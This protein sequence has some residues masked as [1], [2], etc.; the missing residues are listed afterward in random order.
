MKPSRFH[1]WRL[2]LLVLIA[3]AHATSPASAQ[4]KAAQ[5]AAQPKASQPKAAQPAAQPKTSPPPA[6]TTAAAP[7]DEV[8]ALFKQAEAARDAGK[9][10]EA[11]TLL[12]KAW[13]LRKTW[14]IA[15]NLGLNEKKLGRLPEAAEHLT[16]AL[17]NLPP[18]ADEDA[19]EGLTKALAAVRAEVG[20]IKLTVDVN[21]AQVR[22]GGEAKG[23]SPITDE[24][25]V[26][27]GSV[28]IEVTK[29]GYETATQTIELKK[30]AMQEV[31]FRL[32]PIA[33]TTPERSK[34][35]AYVIGGVGIAA[36]AV[37]G[38]LVGVAVG[39]KDDAYAIRK[40]GGQCTK[41]ASQPELQAQ[42]DEMRSAARNA[43]V[44]GNAGIG[45]LIGG[46]VV[47]AGAAAYWLWPNSGTAPSKAGSRVVP[48]VGTNG[49]GIVWTGSF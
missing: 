8:T 49:G 34:L 21:G 33:T 32:A 4:P 48:I 43:D 22:V 18:T 31:S 15:G 14:D 45:L 10:E 35:P 1:P 39:K 16:F 7:Q 24:L 44:L 13:G 20:A 12:R 6:V 3:A 30:G 47:V 5:P 28:Q 40:A 46:G 2:A 9:F 42:C 11:A 17:A 27:P 29:D 38:V 23:A 41:E 26:M 36:V 37:G 25:F 19:R